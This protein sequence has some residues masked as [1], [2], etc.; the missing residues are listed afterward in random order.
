MTN[1][2]TSVPYGAVRKRVGR[3]LVDTGI[4]TV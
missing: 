2:S 1:I 4:L 3:G